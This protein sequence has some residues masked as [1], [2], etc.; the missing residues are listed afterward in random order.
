MPRSLWPRCRWI[1]ISG[2]PSWA[3]STA[4]AW[5][6]WWGAKRRRTPAAADVH[7]SGARAAAADHD[8]PSCRSVDDAERTDRAFEAQIDPGR[9]VLPGPRVHA[10]LVAAAALAAANERRAATRWS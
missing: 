2:T 9:Q 4:W 7:G 6:N 8:R 3:I 1:T 5:R 10:D